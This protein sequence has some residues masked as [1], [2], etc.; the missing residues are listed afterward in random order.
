MKI[1]ILGPGCKRTQEL[2]E[3]VNA[4]LRELGQKVRVVTV[5]DSETISKMGAL[6]TPA[7]AVDGKVMVTGRV[8]SVRKLKKLLERATA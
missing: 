8:L 2:A 3:N 1:Q 4:A 7:L 6:S 5:A